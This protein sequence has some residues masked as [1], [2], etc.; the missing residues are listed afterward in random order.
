MNTVQELVINRQFNKLAR[1]WFR[2]DWR[3]VV[4]PTLVA[5][6]AMGVPLAAAHRYADN[7]PV[8]W[9][10]MRG[11]QK[12]PFKTQALRFGGWTGLGL[13]IAGLLGVRAAMKAP[14]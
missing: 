6:T 5:G 12:I 1:D 14:R 4:T 11:L 10:G 13:G 3:D 9:K 2:D 7:I 8:K